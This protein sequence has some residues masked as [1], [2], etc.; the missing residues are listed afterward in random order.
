MPRRIG[1]IVAAIGLLIVT[2]C[3]TKAPRL[4][5]GSASRS[6]VPAVAPL[7][8]AAAVSG[9]TAQG[10]PPPP[11]ASPHDAPQGSTCGL[12]ATLRPLG[13]KDSSERYSLT[14]TNTSS[15]AVQLVVPGDGS[16][17]GWRTPILTWTA[18][19]EGKPIAEL[20]PARC[21]MMN[22]IEADEIFTLAPGESRTL[23]EWLGEPS[24]APGTYDLTL[25]YRNDP[26]FGA[27][28]APAAPDVAAKLA[29]SSA[30][31]V[32]SDAIRVTFK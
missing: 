4:E 6:A 22:A 3:G 29:S 8:S 12:R 20:S 31:D 16:Q 11:E 17:V 28:K 5:A 19:L 13:K 7:A 24:Y 1:A 30:C 32:T 2:A 23:I 14:L 18:K 26:L 21:G 9:T 10:S 15:Q 25:R 27:H